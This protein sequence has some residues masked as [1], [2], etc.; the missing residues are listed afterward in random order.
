[1]FS[2]SFETNAAREPIPTGGT[3]GPHASVV[4]PNVARRCRDFGSRVPPGNVGT[5]ASDRPDVALVFD[6]GRFTI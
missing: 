6:P 2:K 1:M 4:E 5:A 3:R